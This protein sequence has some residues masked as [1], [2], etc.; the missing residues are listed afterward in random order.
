MTFVIEIP[1][2]DEKTQYLFA[3]EKAL[4]D[5]RD[6]LSFIDKQIHKVVN[7]RDRVVKKP[8]RLPSVTLDEVETRISYMHVKRE[9]VRQQTNRV[10]DQYQQAY[11]A[12]S[13]AA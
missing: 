10:W 11:K 8:E 4:E 13:L 9:E 3:C 1:E 2:P 7:L 5:L 6:R 12:A